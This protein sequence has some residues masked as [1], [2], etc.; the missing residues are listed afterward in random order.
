MNVPV[1]PSS[2]RTHLRI[3]ASPVSAMILTVLLSCGGAS[4]LSSPVTSDTTASTW[5]RAEVTL[6]ASGIGGNPFEVVVDGVFTHSGSGTEI[7][8]PGYY[9]GD[10]TWKV[11]FM[12]TR[13]GEWT[14]RTESPVAALDGATGSVSVDPSSHRGLLGPDPSHPGKWTFADGPHVIPMALRMEFF[15]EPASLSEFEAAADVLARNNVHMMETRLLEEYG[16]FGGRHDFV[17]EGDWQNH[18]F[19]LEI[20]NRME[21]RM[22]ALAE[23]GLGAHIMFYSDD[24]GTPGWGGRSETER[25]VIRY[26][27]ARLAPYPVVFWNTGIDIFEYRSDADIDWMGRQLADLD[28]YDHPRSSRRGGGGGSIVMDDETFHSWGGP[29][30]AILDAGSDNDI[31]SRMDAATFP[32]SFDDAWGENRGSH[33]DK[34]HRPAD[35]RR[36]GWKSLVTGGASFLIRGGGDGLPRDGFYSLHTVESDWESEQWLSLIN[37]FLQD[38]LATTFEAMER[39]PGLVSGTGMH[40]LADPDREKILY[41]SIGADDRY[42]DGGGELTLSLSGEN[43]TWEG[44]W[45]DPRDGSTSTAGTFDGGQNHTLSPP[46]NDDW[47]LLLDRR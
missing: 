33:P 42:D 10:G 31:I 1:R 28:P 4:S 19:D 13:S 30:R 16:M 7:R 23:R 26:A 18:R 25:L 11:K 3:V 20:W 46:S 6:Q 39:A 27:V 34:D 38:R 24:G 45:F 32:V 21:E 44:T 41:L 37:P 35:I 5:G 40:A 43:G 2:S 9:D 14:F 47:I 22:E 17:F 8:M 29:N 12:P 15:S 36:A